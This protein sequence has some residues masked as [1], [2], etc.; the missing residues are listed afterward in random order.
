[1]R[2]VGAPC[3]WKTLSTLLLAFHP[4]VHGQRICD[5]RVAIQH[6][7]ACQVV[8]FVPQ[9]LVEGVR[10]R[11]RYASMMSEVAWRPEED[12]VLMNEVPSFTVGK[13]SGAV[14]FWT[15]LIANN[16]SLS[17]RTVSECSERFE[18]LVRQ[19]GVT[20][21]FGREPRLLSSWSE[22]QDG[23]LQGTSD[24]RTVWVNVAKLGSLA[25]G[26]AYAE[27]VGGRVYELDG[28]SS[29][30]KVFS[31]SSSVDVAA[32]LAPAK[33]NISVTGD[34]VR[35]FTGQLKSSNE[36][37]LPWFLPYVIP[38]WGCLFLAELYVIV[39]DIGTSNR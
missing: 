11:A 22:L 6:V 26:E 35:T 4:A 8:S 2:Q 10:R 20:E 9:V 16:P 12:R 37:P 23:R 24:G 33:A 29:G 32:G 25:S 15:A 36:E 3:P 1:M 38:T 31:S 19:S 34:L 27:S 7:H 30:L 18:T 5:G 17:Q 28:T 21:E 13:G 39:R 14:T